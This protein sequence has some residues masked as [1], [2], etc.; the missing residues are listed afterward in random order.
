MDIELFGI[1]RGFE[2]LV[3]VIGIE[4]V[5]HSSG[6]LPHKNSDHEADVI[7]EAIDDLN[8]NNIKT[9]LAL[10]KY[11][12]SNLTINDFYKPCDTDCCRLQLNNFSNLD[13][14]AFNGMVILLKNVI[15]WE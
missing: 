15:F 10:T 4:R 13:D 7:V 8:N 5:L 9:Y 6:D 12:N 3:D 2:R 14:I 1:S 11:S